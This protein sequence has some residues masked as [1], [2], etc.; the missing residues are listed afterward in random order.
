MSPKTLPAQPALP[1]QPSHPTQ[2]SASPNSLII[3]VLG[4]QPYEAVFNAMVQFTQERDANTPNE[5]WMCEHSP[6]YTQGLAGKAEHLIDPGGVPVIATN[7]GGQ[8][9]YHGLGQVVAYPLIDLKRAGYFVKEYVYRL[10]EAAIQTLAVWGIIGH[11]VVGAPGIYIRLND[12]FSHAILPN[13][14]QFAG[15]APSSNTEL[16]AG[17]KN[18]N[19][20]FTGLGKIAAL[21]IKVSKNCT[22]HGLSLNVDMDLSAFL[23]INPCGYQGLETVDMKYC[24]VQASWQEVSSVLAQKLSAYLQA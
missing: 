14:P 7:R 22:Y 4:P 21:G 11:R 23:K 12:P 15:S 18:I 13:K 9:T 17:P 5:L 8:V 20:D 19:P 10:E 1:V 6:V 2:A 24:G 16:A 3:T